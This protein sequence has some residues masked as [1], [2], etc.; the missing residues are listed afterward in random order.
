MIGH[1]PHQRMI[2]GAASFA[3]LIALSA[4]SLGD[5]LVQDTSREVAKGVVNGVV[6]QRFPGVNAA[7]YTDCIIDNATT[8]EIIRFATSAATN[9]TNDASA[10]VVEIAAR[11]AATNCI[12]QNALGSL[13]R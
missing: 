2:G 1:S 4:C 5:P 8:D 10:L 13:L 7:P 12:A 6:Q 11:P 3:A 9:N